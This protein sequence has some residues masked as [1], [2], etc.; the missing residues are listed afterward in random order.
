MSPEG[1]AASD[2]LLVAA[3]VQD[4]LKQLD[5]RAHIENRRVSFSV[6]GHSSEISYI[7]KVMPAYL[8]AQGATIAQEGEEADLILT[9]VVDTAGADLSTGGFSIPIIL[10]SLSTGLTVTKIDFVQKEIQRGMCRIWVYATETGQAHVF[11]TDPVHSQ[12]SISNLTIFGVSLGQNSDVEELDE[13]PPVLDRIP[14]H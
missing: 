6:E 4:A 7:Q 3:S 10:P 8:M 9:F 1:R 14:I 5:L 11:T 13:K 2:Q 12:N